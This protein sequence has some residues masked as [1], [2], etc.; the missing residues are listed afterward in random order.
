MP[1]YPPLMPVSGQVSKL[2]ILRIPQSI[3]GASA[4]PAGLCAGAMGKTL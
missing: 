2:V 3:N 4:V 1:E